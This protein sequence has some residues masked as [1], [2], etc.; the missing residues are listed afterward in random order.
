MKVPMY[1]RV[2]SV[3]WKCRVRQVCCVFFNVVVVSGCLPWLADWLTSPCR[4]PSLRAGDSFFS[5]HYLFRSM[6]FGVVIVW[7]SL[8]FSSF[9]LLSF[10]QLRLALQVLFAVFL[11]AP[12]FWWSL[13]FAYQPR[14]PIFRFGWLQISA[15]RVFCRL[16]LVCLGRRGLLICR[17]F[18]R[19]VAG[20]TFHQ[21]GD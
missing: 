3:T 5:S 1:V 6:I 14:L 11:C 18:S 19:L 4:F 8:L 17:T 15:I 21:L 7:I 9:L 12:V 10:G 16:Q 20:A 2:G 13:V